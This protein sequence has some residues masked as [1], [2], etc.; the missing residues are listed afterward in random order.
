MLFDKAIK[1]V[2]Q[3]RSWCLS[4]GF[5][6]I[7]ALSVCSTAVQAEGAANPQDTMQ[8]VSSEMFNALDQNRSAL[9]KNQELVYPLVE[10][11]LLPHFDANYAGKLVLGTHWSSTTEDQHQRFINALRHALTRLYGAAIVDFSADRLKFLPNR[12][13]PN[14]TEAVVRSVVTRASGTT[15]PVD[16]RLHLVNGQWLVY[17]VVIEG[18]SYV[19]NYRTD[20]GTE[21]DQKG[22]DEVIERLAHEGLT[23]PK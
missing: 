18:V 6:T 17:D 5:S 20:L 12:S 11:I 10:K 14:S 15:V 8:S 2:S 13:D 4:V 9:R 19:R 22:V 23:A 3:V 1:T 21:M 7:V 16:Y